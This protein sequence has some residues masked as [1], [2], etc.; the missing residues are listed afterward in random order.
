M[1]EAI[2]L[3]PGAERGIFIV[4]GDRMTLAARTGGTSGFE[5]L[6]RDL[7]VGECLCG[8]AA[9]S[10][11]IVTTECCAADPRH[12]LAYAWTRLLTAI[13]PTPGAT[14]SRSRSSCWTSITYRAKNKGRNRV[15]A[16]C[17]RDG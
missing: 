3:D 7:R 13:S 1:V 9:K 16:A 11:E 8:L 10:G 4:E 12:T 15:E 2:P 14:A 6:H 5:A 17:G